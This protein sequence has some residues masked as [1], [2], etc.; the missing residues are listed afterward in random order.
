MPIIPN[1]AEVLR[2]V[3]LRLGFKDE[4]NDALID[5]YITEIGWRIM[6]YC[7][8]N[9]IPN[10]LTHVWASMVMDALRVEQSTIPE[11]ED[12]MP[13]GLNTKIGDTSVSSA[14]SSGEVTPL[15]KSVIDS[16]VLNYKADL[17]RY[18]RVRW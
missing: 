7:N 18:R 10:D 3:K 6:H 16:I 9:E 5:S 8:I 14:S 15:N 11:I 1:A 4:T 2:I 17:I 12:S 13:D